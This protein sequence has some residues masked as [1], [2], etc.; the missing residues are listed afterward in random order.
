MIQCLTCS[1]HEME[2]CP[3]ERMNLEKR[4]TTVVHLDV[5]QPRSPPPYR[6]EEN[7]PQTTEGDPHSTSTVWAERKRPTNFPLYRGEC[8]PLGRPVKQ[9][10]KNMQAWKEKGK[11]LSTDDTFWCTT[12]SN[13]TTTPEARPLDSQLLANM[14]VQ[15]SIHVKPT[16]RMTNQRSYPEQI[17]LRDPLP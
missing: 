14:L 11:N 2:I 9:K 16:T 10:T 12:L 15:F 5:I 6:R 8:H 4:W 13:Y 1:V 7:D 17:P 3:H